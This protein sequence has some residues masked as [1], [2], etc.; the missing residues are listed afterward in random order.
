[1]GLEL[2]QC[3]AHTLMHV[4][5][6]IPFPLVTMFGGGEWGLLTMDLDTCCSLLKELTRS[7]K[8]YIV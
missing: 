7:P 3:N 5:F 2:I 1:M 4:A 6:K 8:F